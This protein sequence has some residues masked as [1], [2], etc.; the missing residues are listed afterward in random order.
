MIISVGKLISENPQVQ[1]VD[2]NPL[3]I[4]EWGSLAV[5]VRIIVAENQH[6]KG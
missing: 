6:D 4:Y 3:F 5:D 2:I 1:S